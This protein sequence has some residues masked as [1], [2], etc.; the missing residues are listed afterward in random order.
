MCVNIYIYM[1]VCMDIHLFLTCCRNDSLVVFMVK[2][3]DTFTYLYIGHI[4]SHI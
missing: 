1:C 2:L 4:Y 3:R